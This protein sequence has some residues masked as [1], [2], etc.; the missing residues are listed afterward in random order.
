[1]LFE[2]IFGMFKSPQIILLS[3]LALEIVLSTFFVRIISLMR[4][5]L[6]NGG[7]YM[8][9]I[10]TLLQMNEHIKSAF[11]DTLRTFKHF[12]DRINTPPCEPVFLSERF[13]IE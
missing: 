1:M 8:V 4:K 6:V 13:I 5:S 2:S 7:L 3:H 10:S 12:P 9:I 11:R